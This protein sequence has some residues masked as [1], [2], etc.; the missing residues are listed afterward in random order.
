[1]KIQVFLKYAY[2]LGR[3]MMHHNWSSKNTLWRYKAEKFKPV[4]HTL[5]QP[6][7]LTCTHLVSAHS[8]SKLL[9]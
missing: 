6:V 3:V 9:S 8:K 1:M 7:L 4:T 5:C 2:C